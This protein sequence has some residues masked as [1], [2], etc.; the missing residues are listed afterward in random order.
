MLERVG[1]ADD[2]TAAYVIDRALDLDEQAAPLSRDE[3]L[4]IL[5]VLSDPPSPRLAE[6]RGAL[7]RDH[8]DRTEPPAA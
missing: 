8:R 2:V 4:A 7:A 1:R 3:H 6:L 5:S